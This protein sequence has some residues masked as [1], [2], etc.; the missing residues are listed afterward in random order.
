[1]AIS[2]A[3]KKKKW[4]FSLRS[5]WIHCKSRAETSETSKT[6]VCWSDSWHKYGTN[7][8][9]DSKS[10]DEEWERTLSSVPRLGTG[11]KS[12]PPRLGGRGASPMDGT[13]VSLILKRGMSRVYGPGLTLPQFPGKGSERLWRVNPP[14]V[15]EEASPVPELTEQLT[16][17][18]TEVH[19]TWQLS[20]HVI[21]PIKH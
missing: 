7:Q 3:K 5:L 13:L 14:S 8:H 17:K 1:M 6:R 21:Y 4:T 9:Q 2:V 19:T 11:R 20:K 15:L 16:C 18:A 10:P 12:V